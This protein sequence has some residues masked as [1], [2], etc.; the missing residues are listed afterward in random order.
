M[1]RAVLFDLDDTLIDH[2]H[3]AR[4]AMLGVR[5]RFAPF[6]AVST[7]ALEREHQR[8]LDLLHHD[9]AIGRR[10][11]AEARIER[12]RQ[13][14]AFV[15]DDGRHASAAAELHRRTYQAS[16]KRVDGALELLQMLQGLVQV[17]VV[18]NNTSAEQTEKLATFELAPFVRAL[19]TSEEVGVAKPEATIFN[20]ALERLNVAPEEAVMVGDSWLHDVQG[21][22]GAGISPVWFNRSGEPHP[23]LG[24][25]PEITA[26]TPAYAIASQ[27]IAIQP[28]AADR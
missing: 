15:G 27:L 23:E 3:A 18:T 24:A 21:A 10:A 25:V 14:F 5:E 13:L 11:I 9:V 1:I 28:R 2:R 19:V 17:G 16:R 26:L 7:D 22:L 4:A 8:I 6:R 12:Y 20:V